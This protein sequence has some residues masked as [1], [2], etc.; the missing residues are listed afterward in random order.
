MIFNFKG[1]SYEKSFSKFISTEKFQMSK[2]LKRA[3]LS[4]KKI[5]KNNNAFYT[6]DEG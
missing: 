4:L 6:K 3:A 5:K 2:M 1:I